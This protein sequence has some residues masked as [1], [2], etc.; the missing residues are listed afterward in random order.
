MIEVR[1][2][3]RLLSPVLPLILVFWLNSAPAQDVF[4]LLERGTVGGNLSADERLENIGLTVT[5]NTAGRPVV[6][7]ARQIY[8]TSDPLRRRYDWWSSP[9][10]PPQFDLT[11]A[12]PDSLFSLQ[13]PAGK[14]MACEPGPRD[15]DIAAACAYLSNARQGNGVN[16]NLNLFPTDPAAIVRRGRAGAGSITDIMPSEALRNLHV[17]PYRDG[18][19]NLR[20]GV[21]YNRA[22][23]AGGELRTMMQRFGADAQ[24]LGS[25]VDLSVSGELMDVGVR[26]VGDAVALLST[27]SP[28]GR[29]LSGTFIDLGDDTPTGGIRFPVSD[30]R[31]PGN[32][33][34]G[35]VG[36]HSRSGNFRLAWTLKDDGSLQRT[37]AI[38]GRAFKAD[39]TPLTEAL[40]VGIRFPGSEPQL[41]IAI[42]FTGQMVVAYNSGDGLGGEDLV[43]VPL[44]PRLAR[45]GPEFRLNPVPPDSPSRDFKVPRLYWITPSPGEKLTSEDEDDL[46]VGWRD[47]G[48]TDRLSFAVLETPGFDRD[49]IHRS[50]FDISPVRLSADSASVT[51]SDAGEQV[52]MIFTINLS[53]PLPSLLP[54][55]LLVGTQPGSASENQDYGGLVNIVT[56]LPGATSVQVPVTVIGDDAEEGDETF[57]LTATLAPQS[58]FGSLASVVATGTIIDDDGEA[59]ADFIDVA[60]LLLP[61][62]L[63]RLP[64]DFANP[65]AVGSATLGEVAVGVAGSGGV[66]IYDTDLQLLNNTS[67][68]SLADEL[69]VAGALSN[70][71]APPGPSSTTQ[72]STGTP[73]FGLFKY[74]NF[75]GTLQNGTGGI[76]TAVTGQFTDAVTVGNGMIAVDFSSNQLLKIDYV[77]ASNQYEYGVRLGGGV[78]GGGSFFTGAVENVISV[79][80][81]DADRGFVVTADGRLY[82]YDFGG[83]SAAF[84]GAVVGDPL[85]V[86]ID[87]VNRVGIVSSFD[88]EAISLFTFDAGLNATIGPVIDLGSGNNPVGIDLVAL[89]NRSY[90]TLTGFD[91]GRY[92]NAEID[93]S[94]LANPVFRYTDLPAT[95]LNPGHTLLFEINEMAPFHDFTGFV[96]CRGSDRLVRI[97]YGLGDLLPGTGVP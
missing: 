58:G 24:S 44:N 18:S 62:G 57:T 66:W 90:A 69:G 67:F 16:I 41:E 33:G 96:T 74:S 97:N 70:A 19:D 88:Q 36:M 25:P 28:R 43:L 9:R 6:L 10:V 14:T 23:P 5:T 52:E 78:Q 83:P 54:G 73:V 13:A 60:T 75:S 84:L 40:P 35:V 7:G 29:K 77:P 45:V 55:L 61:E 8:S 31:F 30:D 20:V 87:P 2:S 81:L 37:G 39:G 34:N 3:R 51:E 85:R 15:S 47:S 59:A 72:G 91:S 95:C 79:A 26:R 46:I 12:E 48:A 38:M 71:V 53:S 1:V 92:V 68:G 93:P 89:G 76:A 63:G 80:P 11:F 50:S 17:A 64:R 22:N 32:N 27:E 94:N 49:L 42:D 21:L 65:S 86:R 4:R 56:V 82:R